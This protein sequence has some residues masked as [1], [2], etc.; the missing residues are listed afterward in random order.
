MKNYVIHLT[1][2]TSSKSLGCLC[3]S[4]QKPVFKRRREKARDLWQRAL[5]DFFHTPVNQGWLQKKL[6]R[7]G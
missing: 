6:T 1:L 5:T 2:V 7:Q 3:F 4:S